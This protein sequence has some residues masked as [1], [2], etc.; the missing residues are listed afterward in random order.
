MKRGNKNYFQ[1]LPWKHET[2]INILLGSTQR[3]VSARQEVIKCH[4]HDPEYFDWVDS[5]LSG[6]CV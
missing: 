4:V 3:T 5:L 2:G 6:L 1:E